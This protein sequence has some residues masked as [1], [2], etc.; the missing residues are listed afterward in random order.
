MEAEIKELSRSDKQI[1]K[2]KEAT[3]AR[4]S[5]GRITQLERQ[6]AD[7]QNIGIGK[8]GKMRPKFKS[9]IEKAQTEIESLKLPAPKP[10]VETKGKTF[11]K[12]I[13]PELRKIAREFD[14][15]RPVRSTVTDVTPKGFGPAGLPPTG[16]A[17]P[18]DIR[19]REIAIEAPIAITRAITTPKAV[20]VGRQQIANF[21]RDEFNIPIRIGKF[22]QKAVGIFKRR[23]E[24]IRLKEANDLDTIS[25]EIGH[26][27]EKK[28]FGG[29][30]DR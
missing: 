29:I 20:A 17:F 30:G 21:F 6:I 18:P 23:E 26:F 24:V 2:D 14:R 9:Q 3:T 16:K 7:L 15:K 8:T 13:S 27:I 4:E 22:R 12:E 11:A 5:A 1:A 10:T 28:A 19:A 25:H